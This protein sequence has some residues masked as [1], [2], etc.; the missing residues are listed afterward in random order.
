VEGI[1]IIE[2]SLGIRKGDPLRGLLFI[3]AHYQ[4]FLETIMWVFSYVF[5]SL[6]DDTH[7]MGPMSEI[8]HAFN[9]LLTQLALIGFKVK[10]LNY[11]LWSAF[12]I[13]LGIEIF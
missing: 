6:V 9:H 10:M 4:V 11:K 1:T 8:T 5:P 13:F 2:S 7:I 12:E 3:L